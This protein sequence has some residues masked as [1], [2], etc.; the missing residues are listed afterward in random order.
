MSVLIL[1]M[2]LNPAVQSRAQA[3]IDGITGKTRLPTYA[4]R[5]ELPYLAALIQETL[6]WYPPIPLGMLL[7]YT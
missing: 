3:E 2:A 5:N 6:R 7:L 4:D 1:A